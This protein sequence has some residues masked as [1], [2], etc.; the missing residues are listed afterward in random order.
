[1]YGYISAVVV[2]DNAP[3]PVCN[4]IMVLVDGNHDLTINGKVVTFTGLKAGTIYPFQV[5]KNGTA[6]DIIALYC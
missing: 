5:T 6:G 1:M 4:A 3:F 2:T